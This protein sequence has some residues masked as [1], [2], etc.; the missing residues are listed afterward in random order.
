MANLRVQADVTTVT[1]RQCSAC[2]RTF[3]GYKTR[4]EPCRAVKRQCIT[5]GAAFT[6]R[7]REC[8]ACRIPSRKCAVCDRIF[9]GTQLLCPTCR[10]TNRGCVVCGAQF[11]GLYR[12][13]PACRFPEHPCI[14]CGHVIRTSN[15]QCQGCRRSTRE[16]ITCGR[17]HRRM[18]VE[19]DSCSGRSRADSGARRARKL[20]GEVAGPLPASA[21]LEVLA[22]GPCVYCGATATHADH[23]RPLARGGHEA[24][25][26]LVPACQPCNQSKGGKLL[27][28]WDP[29]RVS[30]GAARSAAVA[31]ELERE[32][33]GY[34]Q[35]LSPAGV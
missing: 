35:V 25:Y 4:C 14:T 16:C 29:V 3:I 19:C 21:Y 23:V 2:E 28:H 20:A 30:H 12:K 26:N 5:C 34:T 22:S 32:L 13:C 33:N 8:G 11:R 24:V 17:P 31:A 9:R 6:G 10:L 7:T 27:I 15:S 18:T 1:E